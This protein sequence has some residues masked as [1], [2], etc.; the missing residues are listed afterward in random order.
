MDFDFHDHEAVKRLATAIIARAA[1][2]REYATARSQAELRQECELFLSSRSLWH[3]VL[4]LDPARAIR[5]FA[6]RKINTAP[7]A[8][9]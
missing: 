3:Q 2:D 4:G 9:V 5:H 1:K 8:R 7:G 6:R